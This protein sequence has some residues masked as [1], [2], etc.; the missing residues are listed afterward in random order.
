MDEEL[1]E[2]FIDN[3]NEDKELRLS[4]SRLSALDTKGPSVL[5][6]R[7][8]LDNIGIKM[9]SLIDDLLLSPELYEKNY[10]KFDGTKPTA[11]LGKLADIIIDNYI[12]IP[13]KDKILEICKKNSFWKRRS[14]ENIISEFDKKNFYDYIH[15]YIS[16]KDKI[17]ITSKDYQIANQI[18]DILLTHKHSKDIFKVEDAIY[19]CPFIITIN[20]VKLRG[21]IDIVTIDHKNK[22]VRLIDLKTGA[23]DALDFS[24][25]F[26]K[27]R[28]YFQSAIYRKAFEQI[29]KDFEIPDDYT[30]LPFQ[31]LYISRNE[32]I[33]VIYEV[34][35]MWDK[36]AFNG[37]TFKGYTY[38]GIIEL[39]EDAKWYWKNKVFDLPR[40]VYENNGK[41]ILTSNQIEV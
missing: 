14:D 31:F 27:H 34:D 37:F 30:L 26:Y 39:I 2:L 12:E 25:N 29:K 28:Y 22:T 40:E 19:Q 4:Y 11:T 15:A 10:Y 5:I 18:K 24:R 3:L 8:K 38:K 7:P 17:L 13:P 20:D 41:L 32:R 9:G 6:H 1:K 21:I 36:A 33:P 23:P 35:D 16:S